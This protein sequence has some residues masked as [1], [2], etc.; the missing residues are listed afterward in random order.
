MSGFDPREY[1]RTG[2]MYDTEPTPQSLVIFG[3]EYD[4]DSPFGRDLGVFTRLN[5]TVYEQAVADLDTEVPDDY[6]FRTNT[7]IDSSFVRNPSHH[8]M[9]NALNMYYL[10]YRIMQRMGYHVAIVPREADRDNRIVTE[11]NVTVYQREEETCVPWDLCDSP[12]RWLLFRATDN[13]IVPSDVLNKTDPFS[14][15]NDKRLATLYD[16]G[17]LERAFMTAVLLRARDDI[18]EPTTVHTTLNEDGRRCIQ[19]YEAFAAD[20]VTPL[21]PEEIT[22]L[23]AKDINNWLEQHPEDM[24]LQEADAE[25]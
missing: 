3:Q 20:G 5:R 16:T 8:V 7:A 22:G 24:P 10:G 1:E 23:I 11:G 2:G 12:G 19:R 14:W 4:P 21:G 25:A 17:L 9:P 13:L 15:Y 18:I 6:V